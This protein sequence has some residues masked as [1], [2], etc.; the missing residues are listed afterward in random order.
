M[1]YSITNAHPNQNLLKQESLEN[2]ITIALSFFWAE[3]CE[4][5]PT[6][7]RSLIGHRG[8]LLEQKIPLSAPVITP[9]R[10]L[11][12]MQKMTRDPF[13]MSST[14][15]QSFLYAY[16]LEFGGWIWSVGRWATGDVIAPIDLFKFVCFSQSKFSVKARPSSK[17]KCL[18][19][20][21]D[22]N[23]AHESTGFSR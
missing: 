16:A 3:I 15:I 9:Y 8:A 19:W 5:K 22:N 2:V 20:A 23:V 12:F 7:K 17:L 4:K 18:R 21:W 10:L 11:L 13:T 1:T 14:P 6:Q